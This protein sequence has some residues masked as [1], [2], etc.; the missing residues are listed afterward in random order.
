[1]EVSTRCMRDRLGSLELPE[2]GE[3]RDEIMLRRKRENVE[4]DGGIKATADRKSTKGTVAELT[5]A[6]K[7]PAVVKVNVHVAT[8]I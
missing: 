2:S 8:Y 3:H 1:M 6:L 4:E 5:N 7:V